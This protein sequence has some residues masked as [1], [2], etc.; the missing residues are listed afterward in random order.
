[1]APHTPHARSAPAKPWR[2][3]IAQFPDGLLAYFGASGRRG[4]RRGGAAR[5]ASRSL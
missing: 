1:M 3:S 2:S 4:S 5:G